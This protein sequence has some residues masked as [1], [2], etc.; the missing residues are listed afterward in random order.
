MQPV[1][2]LMESLLGHASLG[3]Q[4]CKGGQDSTSAAWHP[5]WTSA[6]WSPHHPTTLHTLCFLTSTL[7]CP[8]RHLH[9]RPHP[10]PP[11][12]PRILA[13]SSETLQCCLSNTQPEQFFPQAAA[14]CSSA[15]LTQVD[16]SWES[17]LSGASRMLL[18]TLQACLQ[19]LQLASSGAFDTATPHRAWHA[20]PTTQ[21]LVQALA[22][23]LAG[24]RQGPAAPRAAECKDLHSAHGQRPVP[25]SQDAC[26]SRRA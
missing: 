6:F 12:H 24:H 3:Q 16:L 19:A 1:H 10:S 2:K 22:H 21:C 26:S 7:N 25:S 20:T 4:P 14:K 23:T 17:R 18:N 9:L 15:W 13:G 5:T 8:T 11:R